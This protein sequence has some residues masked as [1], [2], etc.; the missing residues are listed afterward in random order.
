MYFFFYL[1]SVEIANQSPSWK[2]FDLPNGDK[3]WKYSETFQFCS[4]VIKTWFAE[5]PWFGGWLLSHPVLQL[6]RISGRTCYAVPP[7]ATHICP[8]PC[9]ALSIHNSET[10][11]YLEKTEWKSYFW[12]FF[13]P[14]AITNLTFPPVSIPDCEFF[15][16]PVADPSLTHTHA[17]DSPGRGSQ[18]GV[19]R[20]HPTLLTPN[21]LVSPE[22]WLPLASLPAALH[23]A[24]PSD[25]TAE[26]MSW[27]VWYYSA[28]LNL[29]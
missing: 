25:D 8:S 6:L 26:V 1:I 9:W 13:L 2:K 4:W 24:A 29:V 22:I 23:C 11:L 7:G 14:L 15:P 5:R 17:S 28:S 12:G 16:L 10:E 21:L 19:G 3:R 27:E 18:A 20:G